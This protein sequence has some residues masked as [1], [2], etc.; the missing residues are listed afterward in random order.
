M[1]IV[2]CVAGDERRESFR[3]VASKKGLPAV[4]N[5]EAELRKLSLDVTLAG[6]FY[7][8]INTK[9]FRSGEIGMTRPLS[10]LVCIKCALIQEPS[11]ESEE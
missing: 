3:Y 1:F 2:R 6:C 10:D 8:E 11:D 4:V 7:D 9:E 5:Q